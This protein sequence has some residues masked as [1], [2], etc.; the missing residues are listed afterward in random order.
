MWTIR[1]F[2]IFLSLILIGIV[3]ESLW[4]KPGF[5]LDEQ[6]R[7][8]LT[9]ITGRIKLRFVS[10]RIWNYKI[11]IGEFSLQEIEEYRLGSMDET[12]P[13]IKF[14]KEVPEGLPIIQ[15]F[16]YY[17]PYRLSPDKSLMFLSLSSEKQEY[18]PKYFVI[19]QMQNKKALYQR[20]TKTHIEDMAW[21]PD[22]NMFVVLE[23]SSRRSFSITGILRILIAHPNYVSTYYLSIYDRNGT[24]LVHTKVASGLVDG[25]GQISWREQ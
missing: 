20:K 3:K 10:N 15:G 17:S 21:S 22:S 5:K 2:F 13:Y 6:A 18:Y 12:R 7:A 14:A 25:S 19:I 23:E 16:G 24:L 9:K 8:K 4:T 1:I 11:V